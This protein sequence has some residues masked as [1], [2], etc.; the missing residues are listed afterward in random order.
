MKYILLVAFALLTAC[1]P[2]SK[3]KPEPPPSIE[4]L[5]TD[6][7][8]L[9][10]L[11]A[12]SAQRSNTSDYEQQR[13][14]I[15]AQAREHQKSVLQDAAELASQQQF[16][17]AI[18]I[19]ENAQAELPSSREMSQFSEQLSASSERYTQRNLD[20]LVPLKAMQLQKDNALYQALQK[21]A[22]DPELKNAIARHMADVEY[23][24]P[25][26][27]KAGNQALAQN[28]FTKAQQLLSIA[29]QL[30]P[31]QEIAQL[32]ARADQAVANSRK[33]QQVAQIAER[34]Q[35]YREL[36]NAMLQ[37][38]QQRDFLAAREQLALA[39]DLNIHTEEMDSA[40]RLLDNIIANY[41]VQQVDAGNQFYADGKIEDALNCWRQ[42]EALSPT[43][44]IKEKIEKA[45]KFIDRLQQLQK[46]PV[47]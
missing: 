17:R 20:D 34:E 36:S 21:S 33:K 22:S 15:L 26:I 9:S 25:L 2:L 38:L 42:A 16:V 1:V 19:V 43:P 37:S 28:E 27:V 40:Q 44:D 29:N 13:D 3:Q 39:R 5:C 8:Y 6:H 46:Q 23:F 31:S 7:R 11:K 14:A 10:A 35:R 41:V 18:T 12:L 47:K 4:Q 45:Q 30:T 24:S 32:L